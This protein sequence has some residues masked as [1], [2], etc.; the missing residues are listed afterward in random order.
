MMSLTVFLQSTMVTWKS[1]IPYDMVSPLKTFHLWK[2]L[3]FYVLVDWFSFYSS[4]LCQ[5]ACS[6][7]FKSKEWSSDWLRHEIF[8]NFWRSLDFLSVDE[9]NRDGRVDSFLCFSSSTVEKSQCQYPNAQ[10]LHAIIFR[11]VLS[12][13][14][15]RS[16]TRL[17]FFLENGPPFSLR[18]S[19]RTTSENNPL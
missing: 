5:L 12:V 9:F 8:H 14:L 19:L 17:K 16:S 4:F 11:I 10:E 18:H 15:Y 1:T 7:S 2:L 6:L 13:W 3:L